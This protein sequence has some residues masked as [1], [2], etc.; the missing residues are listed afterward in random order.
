MI[1]VTKSSEG[2]ADLA[3]KLTRN[4]ISWR[5]GVEASPSQDVSISQFSEIS[6]S[7]HSQGMTAVT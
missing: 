4:R 7:V 1:E 6:E 5:Q 2:P 3:H